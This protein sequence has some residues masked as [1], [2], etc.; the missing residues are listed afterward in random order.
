MLIHQRSTALL[1]VLFMAACAPVGEP[2]VAPLP[3]GVALDTAGR[4]YLRPAAPTEEFTAA[5][6][7][8][9]GATRAQRLPVPVHLK[10]LIQLP[11]GLTT[12]A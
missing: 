1:A 5:G 8:G 7:H 2:I 11:G 12:G 3:Q 4:A 6:R 10:Q 9:V